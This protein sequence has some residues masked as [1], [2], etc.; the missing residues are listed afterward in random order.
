MNNTLSSVM[1]LKKIMQITP[2]IRKYMSELAK[3]SYKKSP[4]SKEFYSKIGKLGAK[5]K[6]ENA[7]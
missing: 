2:E 3:L 5:K 7:K 1:K 4:R 6:H